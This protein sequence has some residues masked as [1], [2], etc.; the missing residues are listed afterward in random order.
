MKQ[1]QVNRRDFTKLTALAMGGMMA[2]S[3]VGCA[4]KA[5]KTGDEAAE[6]PKAEGE[7]G[8]KKE[9]PA[10]A[11]WSGKHVCQGLNACKGKGKGG[12]NACAGQGKCFTANKHTCHAENECKYQGGCG[13]SVASNECK[14]KG[15]C[16]V[17]LSESTWKKAYEKFKADMTKAG[18]ADKLPEPPGPPKS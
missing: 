17:P 16:A 14:G 10:L 13:E 11:A 6:K 9:E 4:K 3:F 12:D 8:D 18:K 1:D 7:G 5:E 15:E 2:G